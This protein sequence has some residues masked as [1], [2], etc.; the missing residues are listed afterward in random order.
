MELL[1]LI[2]HQSIDGGFGDFRSNMLPKGGSL[3]SWVGLNYFF[4]GFFIFFILFFG[5]YDTLLHSTLRQ[6]LFTLPL[7]SYL[8]LKR[9]II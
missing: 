8:L 9:T 4:F 1:R 6:Y 2:K 5:F 7:Y 3:I